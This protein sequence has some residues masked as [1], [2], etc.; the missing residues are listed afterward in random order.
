MPR[1]VAANRS[2][3]E[4]G[5]ESQ[6]E[7]IEVEDLVIPRKATSSWA[8]KDVAKYLFRGGRA[9]RAIIHH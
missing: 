2:H 1:A 4:A 8:S 5:I 6:F 9:E 3:R 7:E